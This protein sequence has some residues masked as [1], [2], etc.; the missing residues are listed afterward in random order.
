MQDNW[1]Q[2]GRSIFGNRKV[3]QWSLEIAESSKE[4]GGKNIEF[5]ESKAL[6]SIETKKITYVD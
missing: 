5:I 3:G 2:M 4:L 6:L 1:I